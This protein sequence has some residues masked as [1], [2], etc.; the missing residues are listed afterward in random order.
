M[1][2]VPQEWRMYF[3]F[4]FVRN[5]FD[6]LISAWKMFT[7][8]MQNTRWEYP[9]DGK[10]ELTLRD[11]LD[12]V[13][14]ESI[15]YSGQNTSAETK[16][17]HHA[18]PQTHAFN[19]IQFADFVGRFENL[20][21]D[22]GIVLKKIGFQGQLPHWNKTIHNSYQ[23]YFDQETRLIAEQYYTEDLATFGYSFDDT[24]KKAA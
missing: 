20:Q 13:M 22:F 17:R 12:I 14:D 2:H 8:G 6:R 15:P 18:I 1:G 5:P 10:R 16:I 24:G 3:K 7:C 23:S 9:R 4:A 11:F 19:C 21:N